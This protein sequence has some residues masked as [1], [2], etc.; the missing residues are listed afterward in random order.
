MEEAAQTIATIALN[1]EV[2]RNLKAIYQK[3]RRRNFKIEKHDVSLY[4][5]MF[6]R[7]S[8]NFTLDSV[9]SLILKS[10]AQFKINNQQLHYDVNQSSFSVMPYYAY[11]QSSVD[12]CLIDNEYSVYPNDPPVYLI[13][14]VT[15]VIIYVFP[16]KINRTA[17][18]NFRIIFDHIYECLLNNVNVKKHGRF[19]YFDV[20]NKNTKKILIEKL[21]QEFKN[22][23]EVFYDYS[24]DNDTEL[25]LRYLESM[26]IIFAKIVP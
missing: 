15:G 21:S 7:F 6:I 25:K 13:P 22:N 11:A 24:G 23:E 9:H 8:S 20:A 10:I 26:H 14:G 1:P 5:T 17:V 3:I 16:E 12:E 18:K 19:M 2:H 4:A